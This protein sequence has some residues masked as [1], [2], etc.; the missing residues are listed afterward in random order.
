MFH[1]V[2]KVGGEET[3]RPIP[4]AQL[5]SLIERDSQMFVTVLA[6]WSCA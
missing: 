6:A 3:W 2:Q 5:A 4:A 1:Y